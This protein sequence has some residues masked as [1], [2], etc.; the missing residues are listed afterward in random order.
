MIKREL[1]EEDITPE[2]VLDVEGSD[3]SLGVDECGCID[4]ACF[5]RPRLLRE[6]TRHPGNGQ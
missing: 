1:R 4:R 3:T 2:S 6:D 5:L